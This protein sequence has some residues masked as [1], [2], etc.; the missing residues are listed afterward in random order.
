MMVGWS[1]AAGSNGR[2]PTRESAATLR[3]IPIHLI[4]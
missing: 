1:V 3:H 2:K 4:D